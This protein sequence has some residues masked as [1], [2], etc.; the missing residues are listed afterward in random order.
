MRLVLFTCLQRLVCS[1]SFLLLLH[2][3]IC[4][5]GEKNDRIHPKC[6]FSIVRFSSRVFR[7]LLKK[8]TRFK[9]NNLNFIAIINVESWLG[10]T[11][12]NV[13]RR[14]FL[15]QKPSFLISLVFVF[16]LFFFQQYNSLLGVVRYRNSD[17]TVPWTETLHHICRYANI[18]Q[19]VQTRLPNVS[20]NGLHM[21]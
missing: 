10:F 3:L 6:C 1:L 16:S 17:A 2:F 9:N 13:C 4:P 8:S 12:L 15:F 7:S 20:E 21:R 11:W 19:S 18:W 5:R 14:F